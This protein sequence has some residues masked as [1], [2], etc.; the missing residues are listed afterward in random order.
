MTRRRGI[1]QRSILFEVL[2]FLII[3]FSLLLFSQNSQA[4]EWVKKF[5]GAND[6]EGYAIQPLPGGG[7]ILA[8]YTTSSTAADDALIL[9]L[10]AN[11]NKLW[12]KI[13]QG[14][15]EEDYFFVTKA[16]DNNYIAAGATRS[17][18]AQSYDILVKKIDS[19]GR[20]IWQF[21]YGGA[22]D[23]VAFCIEKTSDGGYILTGYTT[24]FGAQ[25][26]DILVIKLNNDGS[27][28]WQKRYGGNQDDWAYA[29]KETNDGNY[30]LVGIT[31]SFGSTTWDVII[32]K[33]DQDGN[34]LW[35]KKYGG[36]KDDTALAIQED[37][38]GYIIAGTTKS[39]GADDN[40]DIWV[41]KIAKN[42]N[43][44]IWQKRYGG[45]KNDA[46]SYLQKA[47]DGGYILTGY[48]TS[49]VN[50]K[51]N[52][53]VLVI[54][55]NNDGSIA[56]QKKYAGDQQ[57]WAYYIQNAPDGGYIITGWTTSF[58]AQ[59]KD[60]LVIKTDESGNTSNDLGISVSDTELTSTNITVTVSTI[61]VNTSTPNAQRRPLNEEDKVSLEIDMSG[62]GTIHLS[63]DRVC[64]NTCSETFNANENV[65]L[66]AT[67]EPGFVFISWLG[68]CSG[69]GTNPV[70]T[71]TL[72]D[73]MNCEARFIKRGDVNGDGYI[74]I[75]DALLAAR[76][77][78]HLSSSCNLDVTDINCSNSIDIADA[79]LIARKTIGLSV[80][81]WRDSCQE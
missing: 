75:V 77:S 26:R 59:G 3:F 72:T 31:T 23:D 51:Q 79:L 29:I 33:I 46:A 53:D 35:Q 28:A 70:C 1:A 27:I 56:W 43:N 10:D 38:D 60:I 74:T 30:I 7:Y 8:G 71:I 21:L 19:T 55:L 16:D 62:E 13:D 47:A 15:D 78:I 61:N 14:T 50:Q 68:D 49:I 34:I 17:F 81:N 22:Q 12:E 52:I 41:V 42:G 80:S 73:D 76:C 39:F 25:G 9:G 67:P 58:G 54:K 63:G 65:T 64:N 45:D 66:T 69:C 2:L 11:G 36:D 5:G 57:D 44:I 40:L 32:I 20:K 18:G 4:N 6:D 48:T 24:S 37:N